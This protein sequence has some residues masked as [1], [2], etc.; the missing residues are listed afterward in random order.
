MVTMYGAGHLFGG[1]SG[2]DAAETDDENPERVATLRALVWAYLRSRLYSGDSSWKDA[3]NALE[4]G[5]NPMAEVETEDA[6]WA[7]ARRPPPTP[8][9]S[10]S[11][12]VWIMAKPLARSR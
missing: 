4:N 5:E 8:R 12:S 10:G 6:V 7:A 9:S 2:Y 11:G 3:V 1:I